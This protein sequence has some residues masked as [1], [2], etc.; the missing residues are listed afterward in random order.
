[1]DNFSNGYSSR[2]YLTQLL[3]DQLKIDLSFMCN[4]GI[5]STDAVIA[6]TIIG[7]GNSLGMRVIAKYVKTELRCV[8]LEKHGCLLYPGYLF[9]KPVPIEQFEELLKQG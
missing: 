7:M 9:S 5:K 4:I 6:R 1:M 2:A 8:F 3:L